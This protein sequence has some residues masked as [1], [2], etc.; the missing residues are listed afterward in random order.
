MPGK[1]RRYGWFIR[2]L[3]CN[4][5][6]AI[7]LAPFGIYAKPGVSKYTINEE[8]IHWAQQMEMGI[9]PFYLWY[10]IEWLIKALTPPIG[11]YIALGFE[12][13]A[14]AHKYNLSYLR[15]RKHYAW[16]KYIVRQ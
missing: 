13:E 16:F 14:K 4:W 7:T 3:T 8:Q 5:P 15:T 10:G 6:N 11:A 9:L 2:L 12:R 1:V